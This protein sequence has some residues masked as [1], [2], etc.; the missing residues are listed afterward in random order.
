MWR[1]VTLVGLVGTEAVTVRI[2]TRAATELARRPGKPQDEYSPGG[3][4]R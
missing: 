2:G 4:N 1:T 3:R